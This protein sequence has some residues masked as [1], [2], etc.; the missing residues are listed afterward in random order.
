M[1][2]IE[3]VSAVII[4]DDKILC[5]KRDESKY[6]YISYKWEFPGGKIEQGETWEEALNRELSE[7]MNLLVEIKGLFCNIE[8][9]YPDFKLIMHCFEC[10]PLRDDFVLNVHKDSKWL[11]KNELRTL[12]WADADKKIVDKLLTK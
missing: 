8:H 12:D 11:S 2:I 10:T 4:K 7:E 5:M 1:K 9:D 3:V 6:D